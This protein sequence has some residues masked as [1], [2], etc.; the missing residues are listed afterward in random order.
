MAFSYLFL[1]PAVIT[2]SPESTVTSFQGNNVTLACAIRGD[3]KPQVKW[4]YNQ[5][6]FRANEVNQI[7]G[8]DENVNNTWI[9]RST[10]NLLYVQYTRQHGEYQCLGINQHG[11]DSETTNLHVNGKKF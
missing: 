9:V 11:N 8:N 5:V 4:Y 10:L 2:T 6:P 1:E 3:P 7:V